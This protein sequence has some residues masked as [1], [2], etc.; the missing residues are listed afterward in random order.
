[1]LCHAFV[2]FENQLHVSHT[3]KGWE[4]LPPKISNKYL[5]EE[6]SE[7]L[8]NNGEL[9]DEGVKIVLAK[10]LDNKCN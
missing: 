8:C 6:I 7:E 2:Y 9:S 10:N 1:M 5:A 3:I 4:M